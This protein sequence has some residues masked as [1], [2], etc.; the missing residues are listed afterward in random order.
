VRKNGSITNKE[1]TLTPDDELVSSTDPGGKIQFTNDTFCKI[2]GFSNE[3]L[4]NQPHNLVRHPDMPQAAFALLWSRLKEGKPWMGIVKNRCKNGD[5]YWVD[6]YVTPLITDGKTDG[7]ES[8][9]VKVDPVVIARAEQAYQRI[10]NGQR[11]FSLLHQ[12]RG[13]L[14]GFSLFFLAALLLLL[15]MLGSI[16]NLTDSSASLAVLCSFAL[17]GLSTWL[18]RKRQASTLSIARGVIHDPL[19][20]FIYTGRADA[21]GEIELAQLALKARLRTALGRMAESAKQVK[22]RSELAGEQVHLSHL[23]M[24]EQQGETEHIA[25]SMIQMAQA[26]QEVASSAAETSGATGDALHKVEQGQVVLNTANTTIQNLG[27]KVSNL[28]VAV[29]QLSNDNAQIASVVD[30]IRGIAEQTNLLALNAA[31]EAARAGEQGRG[32]AVVADEVR[33]LAARTQESTQHIQSIIEQL[34]K[35]TEDATSS[36]GDCLSI[37]EGSVSQMSNVSESL[38]SISSAVDTIDQMSNR[39]ASAAEEQSGAAAE[40]ESKTQ[41]IAEIS[42]RTQQ[43]SSHANDLSVEMIDLT[44]KQLQLVERF[45]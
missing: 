24:N 15:T 4:L 41:S 2:S 7:F 36:M 32:F 45:N 25:V 1:V 12:L 18:L 9:R 22:H 28:G 16:G 6:A 42:R 35:A 11:A 23:G 27:E 39:I 21:A 38:S 5:H 3:E 44:V 31:I 40:I 10:N 34:G 33:T 17:S 26:V 19:A 8:V 13:D 37:A 30:V 29:E 43:E 20:A 14:I